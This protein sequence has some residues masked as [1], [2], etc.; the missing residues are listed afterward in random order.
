LC[1]IGKDSP[2]E[3]FDIDF[4]V[5]A[6]VFGDIMMHRSCDKKWVEIEGRFRSYRDMVSFKGTFYVVDMSGR[7]HIFVSE[8]QSVIQSH[9]SFDERLVVSREEELLLVQ[10]F[11][12]GPYGREYKHTW[13]RLFRLQEEEGKRRW[14]RINDLRGPMFL[15]YD[16][17]WES[18][19][20]IDSDA[21][22]DRIRVFDLGTERTQ[23]AS[24]CSGC[25][26]VFRENIESPV[27][28]G[29]LALPNPTMSI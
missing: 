22:F 13:F 12:P 10:R 19:L 4:V 24:D 21:I 1:F 17:D 3:I 9:E 23:N 2:R 16:H 8:I 20:F 27:L 28:C 25:I 14:V 6:G 11:T 29:I 5:V 15:G 18:L 26:G 7:G